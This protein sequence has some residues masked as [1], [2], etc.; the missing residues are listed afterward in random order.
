[1][2]QSFPLPEIHHTSATDIVTG[3]FQPHLN[4][5]STFK[6]LKEV[7]SLQ[8]LAAEGYGF[9]KLIS[10]HALGIPVWD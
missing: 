8:F 10:T 4:G 9:P 6:L 7:L 3:N 1:M 2:E 5:M